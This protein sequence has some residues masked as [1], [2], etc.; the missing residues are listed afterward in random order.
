MKM[1]ENYCMLMII[2]YICFVFL[3]GIIIGFLIG[4]KW[5]SKQIGMIYKSTKMILKHKDKKK[6]GKKK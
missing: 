6:T 5:F 2:L 3:F 1:I 4:L